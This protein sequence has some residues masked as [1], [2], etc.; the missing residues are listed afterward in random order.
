MRAARQRR[1][2]EAVRMHQEAAAELVEA[3][4]AVPAEVWQAP[5]EPG[6]WS[7]A[8]VVVHLILAYE[9]VLRELAGA[10]GM[11]VR[12]RGWQR[13]LLRFTLRPRLLAGAPFP[14]G[15]RAPREVRPEEVREEQAETIARFRVLAGEFEAAVEAAQRQR[16]QA[17]LT[18]AYFGAMSLEE[19][20]RFFAVHLRHHQAQFPLAAEVEG[21]AP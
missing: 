17:R 12:T 18:H 5:R 21:S 6:K 7:P 14:R 16:P 1:W 19:G 2:N 10:P 9:V 3:A 15:V 13:L 20:L 4:R 11:A 8:Q